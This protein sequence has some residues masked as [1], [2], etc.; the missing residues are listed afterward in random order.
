MEEALA[1]VGRLAGRPGKLQVPEAKATL[2][3]LGEDGRRLASRLGLLSKWRNGRAHPDV[4]LVRD[5]EAAAAMEQGERNGM[6]EQLEVD[7]VMGETEEDGVKGKEAMTKKEVIE[8]QDLVQGYIMDTEMGADGGVVADMMDEE[9]LCKPGYVQGTFGGKLEEVGVKGM[10]VVSDGAFELQA[11]GGKQGDKG[12]KSKLGMVK[13]FM[14]NKGVKLEQFN[15]AGAGGEGEG[16]GVGSEDG[17]SLSSLTRTSSTGDFKGDG[18]EVEEGF[19][20]QGGKVDSQGGMA[21]KRGGK[22]GKLYVKASTLVPVAEFTADELVAQLVRDGDLDS[23]FAAPCVQ[24]AR[25][26]HNPRRQDELG[27]RR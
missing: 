17:W 8:E 20:K 23:S 5:I 19:I 10:K 7:G 15:G 26:S 11:K 25:G 21:G 27:K 16:G 6:G 2:R 12:Y 18:R 9:L 14:G 1:A 4:C 3:T 22:E 13:G 24:R